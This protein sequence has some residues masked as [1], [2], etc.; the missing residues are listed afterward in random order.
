[1]QTG[2]R[3]EAS[4]QEAGRKLHSAPCAPAACCRKLEALAEQA[5][6]AAT[7]TE[8]GASESEA[9]GGGGGAAAA[10]LRGQMSFSQRRSFRVQSELG[11]VGVVVAA[12][13]R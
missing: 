7:A 5:D 11:P 13:R 8:A 1:L 2:S 9:V 10:H 6:P 4:W 12:A 3:R